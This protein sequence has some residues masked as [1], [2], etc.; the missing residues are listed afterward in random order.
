MA[1]PTNNNGCSPNRVDS[2]YAFTPDQVVS[3]PARRPYDLRHAAVSLWLNAGVHPPEVAER[4]GHRADV[5]LKVYARCIDGR[6]EV[7]NKRLT[8]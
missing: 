2:T 6:H 3:P 8:T 1:H 7:A 4:A 5:L